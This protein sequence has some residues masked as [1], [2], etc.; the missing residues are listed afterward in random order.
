MRVLTW[1][2]FHCRPGHPSVG[3][4]WR[5]TILRRPEWDDEHVHLNRRL[6]DQVAGLI[7]ASRADVVA[8]QE[9][10]PAE[11][12]RL[13]DLAGMRAAWVA[14]PPRV[15]PT[16]LRGALA[17]R[18]PDLWR[19]HE[20]AVN[21]ILVGAGLRIEPASVR[22]LRL[23]PL[24]RVMDAVRTGAVTRRAAFDWAWERRGAVLC[25]IRDAA[26]RTAWACSVHLHTAPEAA[27]REI[28]RLA[29]WLRSETI[30]GPLVVAGDLNLA[31]GDPAL[32]PL[33]AEGLRPVA[34]PGGGIDQILVRGLTGSDARRWSA[35]ER[36]LTIRW[37]GAV[38]RIRVSDHDPVEARLTWSGET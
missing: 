25:R 28:E 30:G 7:R 5:S 8:L 12:A 27:A 6:T 22:L 32:A 1:N 9:V 34:V 19:T 13:A 18:N 24:G 17:R 33:I 26:G 31:P 36:D 11:A 21:A 38:R 37:R 35:G 2:V 3:P 10:P 15:G 29:S 4:T 14:L 23:N 16:A 20:G